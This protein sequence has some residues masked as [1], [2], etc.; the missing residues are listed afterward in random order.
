MKYL[1]IR[2]RHDFTDEPQ[3]L[4]SEIDANRAET[5]KVEVYPSGELG[6]AYCL[7]SN[8]STQLSETNLPSN[9]EIASDSQFEV[10]DIDQKEFEEIWC[11]AFCNR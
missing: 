3:W 8:G 7:E 9:E 5:R 11:S 1:K 10:F 6:F 2:W 4:Y